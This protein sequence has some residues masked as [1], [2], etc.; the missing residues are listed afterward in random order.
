MPTEG[1][2][3]VRLTV[4]DDPAAWEKAG[5][6]VDEGTCWI[7]DVEMVLTGG[8]G[9]GLVSWTLTGVD[10]GALPTSN[11]FAGNG[12]A[13]DHGDDVDGWIDGLA[14]H[15][16]GAGELS[17]ASQRTPHPNGVTFIDHVVVLSPDLDRSTAVLE[18]IGIKSRRVRDVDESQYGF[19]AR[20]V[21][22]RLGRPIL[23]MIGP[24]EP[25]GD[26]GDRPLHCYGLAHTTDDLDG[27]AARLGDDIGAVKDAVQSGRRIATLRHKDLGV[28]LAT[29]FM[30]D[31]PG[32]I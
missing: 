32:S 7:D 30:S 4:A 9:R 10:A 6:T 20:Q 12:D 27:L 5:F 13:N 19:E 16:I 26:A 14:T 22:F 25:L 31:G 18:R 15:L 28:S 1:P 8:P 11:D 17:A 23:E 29:A 2:R 3:L 24:K 21:F